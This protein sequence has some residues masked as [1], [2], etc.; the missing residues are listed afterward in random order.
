MMD[1]RENISWHITTLLAQGAGTGT[2]V[3]V[4]LELLVQFLVNSTLPMRDRRL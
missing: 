4:D 2:V 1:T 3:L